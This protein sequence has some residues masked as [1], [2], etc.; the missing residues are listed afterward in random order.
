MRRIWSKM[1]PRAL[2]FLRTTLRELPFILMFA[3]AGAMYVLL[4][5]GYPS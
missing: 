4:V 1:T 2:S 3:I 5:R